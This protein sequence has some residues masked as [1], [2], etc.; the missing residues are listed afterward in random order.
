MVVNNSISLPFPW[1]RLKPRC[2][3][4]N[5]LSECNALRRLCQSPAEGIAHR[6]LHTAYAG[7]GQPLHH[8]RGGLRV[9][10]LCEYHDGPPPACR[11]ILPSKAGQSEVPGSSPCPLSRSGL[12]RRCRRVRAHV[13]DAP[14]DEGGAW[15]PVLS[16]TSPPL[17]SRCSQV[18]WM[19][20]TDGLP[21]TE[22]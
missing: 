16:P 15:L 7:G 17:P 11:M 9:Q 6:R 5:A 1:K 14:A 4:N 10:V 20:R 19:D 13:P 12:C 2:R 21:T 18:V 3:L 8:R 22:G